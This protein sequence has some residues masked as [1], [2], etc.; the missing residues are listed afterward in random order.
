[1]I[2]QPLVLHHARK[3][4]LLGLREAFTALPPPPPPLSFAEYSTLPT[5]GRAAY[6]QAR[7]D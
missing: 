7:D 5:R 1:M 3:T 4:T 2:V 6:D